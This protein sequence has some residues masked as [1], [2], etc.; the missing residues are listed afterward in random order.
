MHECSAGG[1]EV[2]W[3]GVH[4]KGR[5]FDLFISCVL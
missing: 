3:G 2:G 5:A 1:W 4:L